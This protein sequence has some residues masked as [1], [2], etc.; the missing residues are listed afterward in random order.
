VALLTAG[1]ALL[2]T[3]VS[4]RMTIEGFPRLVSGLVMSAYFAG[5]VLGSIHASRIIDRVGHIRAFA[6]FAAALGVAATLQALVVSPLPWIA[7]RAASGFAIAGQLK[8]AES[9]LNTTATTANRGRVFSIYVIAVYL[10]FGGGQFMLALGDPRDL[11]LFL[12]AVL[13]FSA[14]ILP[15]VLTAAT[16]PGTPPTPRLHL[17]RISAAAPLGLAGA[18][19]AGVSVGAV[20][21]IGPQFA[22]EL[23]L[24]VPRISQFMGV[25][26]LSGILLQWPVGRLSDRMDR[27]RVLAAMALVGAL[28]CVAL[29]TIEH[30]SF[31]V[32]LGLAVLGGGT[33]ATI[34]PLSVAHANDRLRT[35]SVV[36]TTSTLLL[37]YGTG[38]ATGPVLATTVMTG[39]GAA[40]LFYTSAVP[41]TVLAGYA[42]FRMRHYAAVDQSRFEGVAQTTPAV[43]ELDPRAAPADADR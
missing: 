22:S 6:A 39:L 31:V 27:R 12:V 5:F 28:A 11:T 20:Q 9:W 29:A 35:E 15:I 16:A 18:L 14:S 21:A 36:A 3:L 7:L 17:R 24:S 1:N 23:G 40:G 25:F 41:C 19:A 2:G 37:A 34:Y 10:A 8:V 38:A 42:V 4:V 13:L 32:L 33:L 30:R 26:F 43:L